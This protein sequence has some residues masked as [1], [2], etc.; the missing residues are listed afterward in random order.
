MC[1]NFPSE[2]VVICTGVSQAVDEEDATADIFA[3]GT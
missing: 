2:G 1:I 3:D